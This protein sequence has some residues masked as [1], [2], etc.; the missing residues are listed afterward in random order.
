MAKYK[1]YE[2]AIAE[3]AINKKTKQGL[4]NMENFKNLELVKCSG[5]GCGGTVWINK[6]FIDSPQYCCKDCYVMSNEN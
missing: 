4:L 2:K 1:I 6:F 5:N 3:R